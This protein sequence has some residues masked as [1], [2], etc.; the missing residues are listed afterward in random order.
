M[1][2]QGGGKLLQA[3][4]K[5]DFTWHLL[6]EEG[7]YVPSLVKDDRRKKKIQSLGIFL[8]VGVKQSEVK[9]LRQPTVFQR[10]S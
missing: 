3:N 5:G 9:S 6:S 7:R 2:A 4:L 1:R 10:H 8:Q